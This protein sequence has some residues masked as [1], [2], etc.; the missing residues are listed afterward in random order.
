MSTLL[1]GKSRACCPFSCKMTCPPRGAAASV[2]GDEMAS[3]ETDFEWGEGFA[4]EATE[5]DSISLLQKP[6]SV[7][8]ADFWTLLL[9]SMAWGE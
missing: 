2:G 9:S 5:A 3:V 7:D 6:F 4:P 1:D 8:R